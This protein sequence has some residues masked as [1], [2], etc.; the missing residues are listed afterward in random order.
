MRTLLFFRAFAARALLSAIVTLSAIVSIVS[1]ASSGASRAIDAR[2]PSARDATRPE[3]IMGAGSVGEARLVGF[4]MDQNPAKDREKVSRLAALYVEEASLEGVNP[5]VAFAQMC[6]ETGFLRF[7]GLVTEDMHNFCG[8]GSI[9]PG[10]AGN[11]FPD[12]RTGVRAHVQHL[13]AYA[14]PEP[15]RGTLVDPRYRY[16][17][18]KG[19]APTI[20]GLGGTWATDREYGVKLAGLI[21]RLYAR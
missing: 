10:Q 7:G 5:D 6:L 12:E 19:K 20:H 13:K 4:F 18:P 17:T 21:D 8:L 1:C 11:A 2:S 9:G 3:R 14:S 15:L 16:V